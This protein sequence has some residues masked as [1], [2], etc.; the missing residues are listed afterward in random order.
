MSVAELPV[1]ITGYAEG[2]CEETNVVPSK[3]FEEVG[4]DFD[5]AHGLGVGFGDCFLDCV[6]EEL[7]DVWVA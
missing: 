5:F 7:G 4:R 6:D 2:S 1:V 3:V